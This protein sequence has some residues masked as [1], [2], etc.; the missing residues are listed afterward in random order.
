MYACLGEV[1]RG[2]KEAIKRLKKDI[3][4]TL[5]SKKTYN[6]FKKFDICKL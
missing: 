1:R 3:P 6:G 2:V 4:G 5:T